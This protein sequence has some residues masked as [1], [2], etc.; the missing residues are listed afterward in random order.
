MKEEDLLK[1]TWVA[2]PQISPD[3][4][5]VAFTHVSIDA[6]ADEYRTNLWLA[7]VPTEGEAPSPPRALTFSGHDAQPRWSPDGQSLAFVRK[8]DAKEPGQLHVLSLAGGEARALTSLE[9]GVSSA[10]WS[11]D[12]R[13]IAFL[14]VQNPGVDVKEK[15][16]PKNEPA[17]IVTRPEFR[18]NDQGF[19]DFEHLDHVWV[20]DAAG[21]EPR[22]LTR[23]TRCKEAS[24]V[25]TRDGRRIVYATDRR[26]EPWFGDPIEQ[27]EL[28]AVSP[29]RATPSDGDDAEVVARIR[30]PIAAFA[31]G[32]G[33]RWLAVGGI[34]P[35]PPRSYDRNDLLLFEGAWPMT[36][37]R[38]LGEG[39]ELAVGEGLSGDQHPPRGGG[40]LPL[41]IT[42]GGGAVFGYAWQ[43]A[44][45]LAYA[46]LASGRIEEL[47]G[48]DGDLIAGTVDPEGRRVA[49][50]LGSL[51]TPGDLWICDLATRTHVRLFEPNRELIEASGLGEVEEVWYPSFDGARIQGW[52]VKPPGFDP[53]KRYPLVLEIHG[54][55]HV[56]YGVAFFHE[57]RVLAAAGYVVLYTNPRGS[58]S[59]GQEF[60]NCIQYRYP[61]DDYRDLMG[62]VDV[63]L[64][65]G[66]VD[67]S[68]MGVTGGSGGGLLTNWIVTKT[69]RFA[70]AI[71]QRCVADWASMYYSSDFALFTP[72]WFRKAP[73]EDPQEYAERSPATYLA[74]VET[75]LMVIHSEEDWRC[76][77]GQGETMFRGLLQQ[78]KPTVMV[79]F[80]GE[81][82]E[83]SRSGVP[84][85]RVQNQQHIR[86]WFDHWLQD[87]PAPE[88]G[89]A[90]RGEAAS[91]PVVE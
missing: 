83:L 84:S 76:P 27:I 86:R 85:R 36:S 31:E 10:A 63:V 20:I 15:K 6:E 18:W 53:R 87:K 4:S 44:S 58:T 7:G 17:R 67:E 64:A 14:S 70:A 80:P 65:R 2:D 23:G 50:T 71:T 30:G 38:V 57:F 81:N 48:A 52:I 29:D 33:G 25:W 55:P 75:P 24:P 11:P 69:N 91:V 46:D 26:E 60:G 37:P 43:G 90:A 49:Y 56:P 22:Q 47:T 35:T 72:T 42:P 89:F 28:L 59:Y 12:G 74:N 5:R 34:R 16:K 78:R 82:H 8:P 39:R 62:A 1:F 51:R 19:L 41:S 88:Y 9:K 32:P 73:F 40:A 21:G 3:G 54:G 66:Y 61:G 79:R 68:R 45:R 13:R 77:I